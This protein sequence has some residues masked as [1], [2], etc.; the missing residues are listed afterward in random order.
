MRERLKDQETFG[1]RYTPGGFPKLSKSALDMRFLLYGD[2]KDITED[3]KADLDK[4]SEMS[5]AVGKNERK[6]PEPEYDYSDPSTILIYNQMNQIAAKLIG[7]F[8]NQNT[9]HVFCSALHALELTEPIAF[10][11]H[12]NKG[13]SDFLH[14]KDGLSNEIDV[15]MAELLAAAVDAVKDPVLNYLNLNTVTADSA[16][17]LIRLGYS[18][19]E[20]GLLFNQP[21]IK[22][23]CEEIANNGTSVKTAINKISKKYEL[24]EGDWNR[25][26]YDSSYTSEQQLADNIVNGRKI[27]NDPGKFD[28]K[29]R[30]GQLHVLKL[31]NQIQGAASEMNSFVQA[32]RF[33]AANSIDSTWGGIIAM[34]DR[35]A[36]FAETYENQNEESENKLRILIKAPD[37]D[38]TASV[39]DV[40]EARRDMSVEE[41]LESCY[42]NPLAFEQ[43]MFDQTRRMIELFKGY[44]P[45]FS[46]LYVD[47]KKRLSEMTEYG[48]L[49]G[50][51][52]NSACRE[53][54]VMLLETRIGTDFHG[55]SKLSDN[56]QLL[57]NNLTDNIYQTNRQFYSEEFP[58]IMEK[59]LTS[60]EGMEL[61][62][63]SEFFSRLDYSYNQEEKR[64]RL[65]MRGVGGMQSMTSNSITGA[66]NDA[67]NSKESVTVKWTEEVAAVDDSGNPVFNANGSRKM[68]TVVKERTY[69]VA[70]LAKGMYFYNL[71]RLGFNFHATSTM[72]LVPLALKLSLKVG[73]ESYVDF[74]RRVI[75]GNIDINDD[76]WNDFVD[77]YCK[78]YI[79]NHTDNYRFEYTAK[80]NTPVWKYLVEDVCNKSM[81]NTFT[82]NFEELCAKGY[83][84]LLTLQKSSTDTAVA[85]KPMIVIQQ[86]NTK[87][88][89]MAFSGSSTKFNRANGAEK[90]MTYVKVNPQSVK[91]A[92]ISYFNSKSFTTQQPGI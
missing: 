7:I 29:F 45:H 75:A 12:A 4:I 85:Y 33:T 15:N 8:A 11:S 41:Y 63:K 61:A 20:V 26:E 66:W 65:Q 56:P 90:N 40:S 87:H 48:V 51:T 31:F 6:D 2:I 78:Q 44:Y 35:T 64:V 53:L 27:K 30:E 3:G 13:L 47:V 83:A 38:K 92:Y 46:K 1:E 25:W 89:Y 79:L 86:N 57:G 67:L 37:G 71:Y 52:I 9:H 24:H 91:G 42:D 82:L 69:A 16:A 72:H 19:R 54:M 84:N 17:L 60:E 62:K 80:E 76:N 28:N 36:K 10:G 34:M 22:E 70:D 21:I 39:L 50:D 73:N 32:T 49:D 5:V 55:E 68:E 23:L 81:P 58:E 74:V 59:V 14:K 88:Y 43:C 77:F 18:Q